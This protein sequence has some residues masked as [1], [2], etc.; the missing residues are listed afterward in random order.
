MIYPSSDLS[1]REIA[2]ANLGPACIVV[3][4]R[5][6]R[7]SYTPDSRNILGISIPRRMYRE[8]GWMFDPKAQRISGTIQGLRLTSPF[9]ADSPFKVP[10]RLGQHIPLSFELISPYPFPSAIAALARFQYQFQDNLTV[11]YGMFQHIKPTFVR[12]YPFHSTE[13]LPGQIAHC[14]HEEL[15]V[16]VHQQLRQENENTV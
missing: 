16:K 2:I 11:H 3:P 14:M 9:P 10:K 7:V 6:T 15:I 13:Q 1:W 4:T 5:V 12:I 8:S